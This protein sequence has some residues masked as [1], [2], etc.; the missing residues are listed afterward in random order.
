MGCNINIGY[1][2]F[3]T[4]GTVLHFTLRSVIHFEF[5]FVKD[6]RSVST[7]TSLHMIFQLFWRRVLKRLGLLHCVVFVPLLKVS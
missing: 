4:S 7:L 2:Y 6:V 1:S 5:I 3:Y